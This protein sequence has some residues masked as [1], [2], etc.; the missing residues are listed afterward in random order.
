MGTAE[1]DMNQD[2]HMMQFMLVLQLQTSLKLLVRNLL[3]QSYLAPD[4]IKS[5]PVS[6]AASPSLYQGCALVVSSS[7]WHLTFALGQL[8]ITGYPGF[9]GFRALGSLQFSIEHSLPHF[10]N[11]SVSYECRK[12]K[13]RGKNTVCSF[14]GKW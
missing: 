3:R 14:S 5:F 6:V 7:P 1:K 12:R 8:E 10:K 13:Q 2:N 4:L 11:T 9:H